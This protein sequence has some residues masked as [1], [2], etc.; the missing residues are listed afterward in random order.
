[1]NPYAQPSVGPEPDV[2]L[3][4]R[5]PH[6]ESSVRPRCL[7]LYG[8]SAAVCAVST[9]TRRRDRTITLEF[10][11]AQNDGTYAWHE[12]DLFQLAPGELAEL[13][14]LLFRPS[15]A[16][17]FV[18][19]SSALKTLT[20]T[21]QAPHY[22]LSLTVGSVTRRVPVR[23]ADQFQ[24]RNFL[25]LRLAVAQ[26]LPPLVVLQSLWVLAEQLPSAP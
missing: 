19:R 24:L 8:R 3:R 22:L 21:Y 20:L 11:A 4:Q 26:A 17:R 14:A 2:D 1:M 15:K 16:L 5:P 7:H 25:L 23:P 10:A 6:P 18:H 12:K 9:E 13:T